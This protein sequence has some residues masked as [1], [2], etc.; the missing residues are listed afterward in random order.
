MSC[1]N[2]KQKTEL[3][4]SQLKDINE[5]VRVITIEY[6]LEAKKRDNKSVILSDSLKKKLK[7][8][9]HPK[10]IKNWVFLHHPIL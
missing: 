1:H 10:R 4:S 6:N 3:N 8:I 7:F 9:F 5:I 2:S